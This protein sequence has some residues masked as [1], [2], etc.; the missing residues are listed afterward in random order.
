MK[1]KWCCAKYY[2]KGFG[3]VITIC[4]FRLGKTSVNLFHRSVV[5]ARL[6]INAQ[7]LGLIDLDRSRSNYIGE[8]FIFH[9]TRN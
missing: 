9:L 4:W 6:K 8:S 1:L 5:L 2:Q 7:K 3:K